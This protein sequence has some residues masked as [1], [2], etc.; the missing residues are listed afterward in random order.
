MISRDTL[1]QILSAQLGAAYPPNSFSDD[2]PLL[3]SIAELDS[4]AVVGILAAIEDEHGI[5][6]PDDEVSADVFSTF[7]T[8]AEFLEAQCGQA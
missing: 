6:I 1:R 5:A 2:T 8:L 3:G 4:M 7:A